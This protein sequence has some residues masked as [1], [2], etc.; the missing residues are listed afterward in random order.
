MVRPSIALQIHF[1]NSFSK[2]PF[3]FTYQDILPYDDDADILVHA[4]YY[5]RLEK[6]NKSN[7][8]GD[9]EFYL[10]SRRNMK[11]YFRASPSAG[12]YGW[13]WPFIG[14]QFYTDNPTHIQL[15]TYIEKHLIFPLILRP[16]ATLWLPGPRNVHRYL[17]RL[18]KN[19]FIRLSIDEKCMLQAYSHRDEKQKYQKK[20]V[21]CSQLYNAYPYIRR[22]CDNDYC[23]EHFMINNMTTLY[24]LKIPKDK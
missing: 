14:I 11:F 21:N 6:I 18:R 23:H 5:L 22:T 10:R 1:S 17:S 12:S 4:K 24:V 8:K 9:W 19:Y 2:H 7:N 13:N 3:F 20:I 15:N 16:I